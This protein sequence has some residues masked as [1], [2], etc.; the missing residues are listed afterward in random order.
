MNELFEVL[1]MHEDEISAAFIEH[2]PQADCPNLVQTEAG[3][4]KAMLDAI[5]DRR[6]PA[7]EAPARQWAEA[8]RDEAVTLGMPCSEVLTGLGCLERA[9][10]LYLVKVLGLKPALASA[11]A[12]LSRAVD[13]LRR[14]YVETQL[15]GPDGGHGQMLD[16]AALAESV[17]ALVCMATLHGKPL[18]LNPAGRRLVG[19]AESSPTLPL[20]LHDFYSEDSW[21]Q[22]R[23]VAVPA[24]SE[25]GRWQGR[26]QLRNAQTGQL[27]DVLTDMLLVQ[28]SDS[29]KPHCLAI[30]HR[31]ASG[32]IQAEQA[33]TESQARKHAILESALDPIITIDHNGLISEFNRAA[34]QTFGHSRNDVLGTKPS[35]VL[36]PASKSAG[37]QNRINRYLN[38]GEGSLL[39]RRI[40]VTAVRADGETF[41]AEMAMTIS[42]EQGAPVLTFFVR[43]ISQRKKA[44][45]EQARY[46]A[47]LERSNRELEQFA[48]VA[49]HDLQEPLRKIRTFGDRLEMKS[50]ESLDETGREC[51]Q[52][53]Q[54]AA[55]R[56]QLLIE[57]LL[58]LSRV[59]T[60]VKHF[61]P[62]DVGQ[63]VREVVSDLEVQIEQAGGRVEVG[64]LPVIQADAVQIR[65]LMQNLI[66]NALKF[67][68]IDEPPVVKVHGRYVE[69]RAQ[70]QQ[71]QSPADQ[72]CRI[73][74]E[75][76]G[77]GFDEKYIDRVFGVFQRLHPRDVYDGTGIGLPICR[78]I[79]EHHGGTI[80]A[81]STPGRGSA[82]QVVLP[83]AHPQE[84]N[85]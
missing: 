54:S 21:L 72:Q 37:H 11:M 15:A 43:D 10:G 30:I 40:E 19:M 7:D 25:T 53:M 28:R 84:E 57:G 1:Q 31:D 24:V 55:A 33:L 50:A 69:G 46:A 41:P 51:L 85:T 35:D 12:E 79:V 74:I 45:K 62:V 81:E 56:M 58:T 73:F 82:F 27:H 44:E 76:N 67:R 68:R 14:C 17:D 52:R 22:L 13:L 32:Q 8:L 9:A 70:R 83:L 64:N 2:L 18:Y 23:D 63:V 75:D 42:Q 65:Q 4:C 3:G 80:T 36:F 39:G 77:I 49:S 66:G 78:R 61:Q 59:T 60:R 29:D 34:E 5:R 38:A 6:K 26:S 71:A 16:F 48:Y 20:N 47:D